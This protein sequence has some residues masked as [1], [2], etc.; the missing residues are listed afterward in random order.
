MRLNELLEIVLTTPD[1]HKSKQKVST[2]VK[3]L[4]AA[5]GTPRCQLEKKKKMSMIASV[6]W[7]PTF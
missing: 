5:M 7:N 3:M 1:T 6:V 4:A 2:N